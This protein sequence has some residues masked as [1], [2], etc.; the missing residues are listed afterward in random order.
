MKINCSYQ[1]L[2]KRL[3]KKIKKMSRIVSVYFKKRISQ[4]IIIA[5]VN[6]LSED[7]NTM[8]MIQQLTLLQKR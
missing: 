8:M 6:N 7:I 1:S 2:M 5:K 3:L 4:S